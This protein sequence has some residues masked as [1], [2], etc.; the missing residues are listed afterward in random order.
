MGLTQFIC[1]IVQLFSPLLE[2]SLGE[3]NRLVPV[4]SLYPVG[5]DPGAYYDY[6][7]GAS[8]HLIEG[9]MSFIDKVPDLLDS[10]ASVFTPDGQI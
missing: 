2:L 7:S 8:D 3:T 9:C 1:L 10:K 5:I 6:H 4:I